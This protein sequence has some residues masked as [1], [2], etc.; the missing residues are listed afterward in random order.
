MRKFGVQAVV[1]QTGFNPVIAMEL[2]DS[3]AWRGAG[4]L[5]PEAFPPLPFI[6]RMRAYGF[7]Y[8]I[9]DR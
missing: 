3:G 4:V 2:I 5:G 9:Q 6:K 7:P 8:K 1:A